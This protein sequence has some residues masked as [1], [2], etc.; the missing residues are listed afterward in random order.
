MI[1]EQK[2]KKEYAYELLKIAKGDYETAEVLA[3]S[4]KGRS[5]L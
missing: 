2:F 1:K 4:N 5:F 3:T